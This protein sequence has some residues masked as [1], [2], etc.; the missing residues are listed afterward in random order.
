MT[1]VLFDDGALAAEA[2]EW[3][4]TALSAHSFQTNRVLSCWG[5]KS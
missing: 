3:R 1:Q 5:T 2:V 4:D